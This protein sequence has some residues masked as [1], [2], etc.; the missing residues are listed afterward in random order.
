MKYHK[1]WEGGVLFDIFKLHPPPS[2]EENFF[3]VNLTMR[4]M[5]E[6]N[7]WCNPLLP[8]CYGLQI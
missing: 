1:G 4:K 8:I 3:P 5:F 6:N 2:L 7:Q